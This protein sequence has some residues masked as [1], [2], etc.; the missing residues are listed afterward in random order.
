MRPLLRLALVL[1]AASAASAQPVRVPG[2]RALV[3]PPPGFEPAASF[4]GF[5]H[6]ASG[7]SLMVTELVGAPLAE[8]R[9]GLTPDALAT[10][11][12]DDADVRDVTVAGTASTFVEG[13]QE[14]YGQTFRKWIVATGD[15]LGVVLLSAT[16]PV[17]AADALGPGL[18]AALLGAS[19]AAAP[20]DDEFEGLP[21]VLDVPDGL[22][23]RLRFGANL[24]MAD[25]VGAGHPPGRPLLIAGL[26]PAPPSGDLAARAEQRLRASDELT[27]IEHLEGRAI[28]LSG[29]AGYEI[30]ADAVGADL[31]TPFRVYQVL[32]RLDAGYLVLYGQVGGEA[33]GT[34]LP[35]FRAATASLRWTD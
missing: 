5:Q 32:A 27:R 6:T 26:W 29:V 33:A 3:D 17:E 11:G 24:L 28:D 31:G 19:L 9:A 16:V 10:Q 21:F 1:L 18:R 22:P 30:V 23:D 20:P 34:W 14:A 35:R 13:T 25:G 2:T 7:T 12:V 8:I 4:A 15:S